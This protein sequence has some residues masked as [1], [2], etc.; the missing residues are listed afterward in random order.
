MTREPDGESSIIYYLFNGKIFLSL[1][2]AVNHEP[3][4]IRLLDIP[5]HDL[6][7]EDA[8]DLGSIAQRLET[9]V[10]RLSTRA[11]SL[12]ASNPI[13]GHRGCR[14]GLTFPEL[15]EVQVRAL[16]EAI[17]DIQFAGRL[18]VVIPFVSAAEEMNR[19][20]RRII[21]MASMVCEERGSTYRSLKLVQCLSLREPVL[22]LTRS[23]NTPI[24]CSLEPMI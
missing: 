10:D 19:L 17:I 12:L 5:L 20:R 24:F 18:Q 11:G 22:S 7:P 1:L 13:L 8:G 4:S 15:Y 14:L 3:V 23:L 21:H 6:M 16:F 9:T 2:H